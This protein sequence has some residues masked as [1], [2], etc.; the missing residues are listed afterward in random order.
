MIDTPIYQYF[1]MRLGSKGFSQ[2]HPQLGRVLSSF[3]HLHVLTPLL[4]LIQ[5]GNGAIRDG[6]LEKHLP[7]F[8]QAWAWKQ[9]IPHYPSNSRT[10]EGSG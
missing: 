9:L 8:G 3:G 6:D 4:T 5:R 7:E 1:R 10:E 2:G